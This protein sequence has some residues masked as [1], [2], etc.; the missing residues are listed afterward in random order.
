[1]IVVIELELYRTKC[2]SPYLM[3]LLYSFGIDCLQGSC[4]VVAAP[5]RLAE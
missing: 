5:C 3:K 2:T 4:P 1:M